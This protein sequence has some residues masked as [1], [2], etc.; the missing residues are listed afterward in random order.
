[1]YFSPMTQHN[2]VI[3]NDDKKFGCNLLNIKYDVIFCFLVLTVSGISGLPGD[4]MFYNKK[5]NSDKIS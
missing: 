1:M 2:I 3:Y 5:K 4:Q